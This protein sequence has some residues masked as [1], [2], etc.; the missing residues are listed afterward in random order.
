M[1]V[2]AVLLQVTGHAF[3]HEAVEVAIVLVEVGLVFLGQLVDTL[4]GQPLAVLLH[5]SSLVPRVLHFRDRAVC[6]CRLGLF[7]AHAADA[8][9][10]TVFGILLHLR[11]FGI[12]EALERRADL[13]QGTS[14]LHELVGAAVGLH[15]AAVGVHRAGSSLEVYIPDGVLQLN[16]TSV[17]T[18]H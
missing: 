13:S 3:A 16:A 12:E 18:A 6:D 17:C 14:E 9:I 10:G 4:V 8:P 1:R 7:E 11:G 2:I 15:R 5:E